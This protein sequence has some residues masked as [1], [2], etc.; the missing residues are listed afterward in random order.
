MGQ[1]NYGKSQQ[2]QG[3]ELTAYP[4]ISNYIS[5]VGNKIAKV[6]DRPQLPYEFVILNSS[7]PNA[8]ALPGGKIAVNR[9]LLMEMENESELAAVIGHEIVHAAARH[10]AKSMERGILIQGALLGAGVALGDN[11]YRDIILTGANATAVLGTTKYGR[12][13]EYESDKYGIKYM[14]AA[15]Y[16]PIGSVTV[17]EKFLAMKDNQDPSWLQGLVASHP[18]SGARVARNKQ[19]SAQYGGGVVGKENYERIMGPLLDSEQ[20]YKKYDDGMKA[21]QQNNTA[22]AQ[23]LAQQAIRIQ[24]L[25]PLFYSLSSKAYA[26][27]G[28]VNQA[29]QQIDMALARDANYFDY[30]LQKA[31][32]EEARGNQALAKEAYLASNRLLPTATA[33]HAL[34][35]IARKEGDTRQAIEHF[36]VAAAS[37]TPAGAESRAILNG[38]GGSQQPAGYIQPTFTLNNQGYL[39][40]NVRNAS[41]VPINNIVVQVQVDNQARNIRIPGLLPPGQSTTVAAGFGP[42]RNASQLS[43]KISSNVVSASALR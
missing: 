31:K 39:N 13:A 43:G 42:Y 8:W 11:D 5:S 3:G 33:H 32:L 27:E 34:G 35:L 37:D 16:D 7:V 14:V 12:E 22:L 21:L 10:G 38:M 40:M 9:G 6:S 26:R 41:N 17:Q 2:A 1:Q 20:A 19:L 29:I 24:P 4:A 18:P 15:G 23:D 30:H 36:K 28:R 25:E